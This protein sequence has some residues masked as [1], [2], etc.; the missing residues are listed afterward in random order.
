MRWLE[1]RP[2]NDKDARPEYG[3][4]VTTDRLGGRSGQFALHLAT[5][6]SHYGLER[7]RRNA[8]MMRGD[9]V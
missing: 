3:K 6:R 1:A 7:D 9:P 8:T 5:V 2:C 4:D